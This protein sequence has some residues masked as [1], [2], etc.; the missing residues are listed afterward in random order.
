MTCPSLVFVVAVFGSRFRVAGSLMATSEPSKNLQ[1]AFGL[2]EF[3]IRRRKAHL[4]APAVV[5]QKIQG[6][7]PEHE[8][9]G[10]VH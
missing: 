8:P 9:S 5:L 10:A 7:L 6:D 4:A 3:R 1:K 2:G